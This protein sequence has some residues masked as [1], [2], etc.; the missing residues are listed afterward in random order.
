[1][2]K[3]VEKKKNIFKEVLDRLKKDFSKL[4]FFKYFQ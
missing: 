4:S 2:T 1:M 3:I